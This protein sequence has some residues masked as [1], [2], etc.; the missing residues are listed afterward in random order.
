[1]E[2]KKSTFPNHKGSAVSGPVG[3]VE[4]N[5]RITTRKIYLC[6]QCPED[7]LNN[8]KTVR[9]VSCHRIKIKYRGIFT[10]NVAKESHQHQKLNFHEHK[11]FSKHMKAYH[12]EGIWPKF[13]SSTFKT[14]E[15]M[16]IWIKRNGLKY[17]VRILLYTGV[18][19]RPIS[20]F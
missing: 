3:R 5:S 11:W 10:R 8:S 7:W 4:D 1:M 19:G 20:K 16:D 12:M 9:F 18:S 15:D 17:L 14:T 13:Q 6:C 2:A